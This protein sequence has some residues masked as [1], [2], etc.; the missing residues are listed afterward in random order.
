MIRWSL[1]RGFITLP[2]SV[3]PSRIDQNFDIFSFALTPEDMNE[4]S[5]LDEDFHTGWDP[6]VIE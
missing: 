6:T 3:T 1:Q 4:I 2:K 5:D